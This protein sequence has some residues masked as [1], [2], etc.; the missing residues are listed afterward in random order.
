M[1]SI[2]QTF[3]DSAR[4]GLFAAAL[5]ALPLVAA[6]YGEFSNSQDLNS[7]HGY[8]YGKANVLRNGSFEANR[9]LTEWDG[10]WEGKSIN[11]SVLEPAD[12]NTLIS[13]FEGNRQLAVHYRRPAGTDSATKVMSDFF[14]LKPNRQYTLTI[15]YR[16]Q[17]SANS[18]FMPVLTQWRAR[19]LSNNASLG[20]FSPVLDGDGSSFLVRGDTL[21]PYSNNMWGWATYQQTFNTSGAAAFGTLHLLYSRT[22]GDEGTFAFDGVSIVEG[23]SP[24]NPAAVTRK[25]L[26]GENRLLQT[27]VENG[28]EAILGAMLYDSL[29]RILRTALPVGV[30]VGTTRGAYYFDAL[31]SFE[32]NDMLSSF[33]NPSGGPNLGPVVFG[34]NPVYPPA[35][36]YPY[37]ETRYES[38]PLGRVI[39]VSGPGT[40]W[41]MGSGHTATTAYSSTPLVDDYSTLPAPSSDNGQFFVK[42]FTSPDGEVTREF[43][44]RMGRLTRRASLLDGNWINTDYAYDGAGNLVEVQAPYT[45]GSRMTTTKAFDFVKQMTEETTPS[46]GTTTFLYD[47][48]GR[49]RFSSTEQQRADGTFSYLKYDNLGRVLETGEILYPPYF[50]HGNANFSDFPCLDCGDFTISP[51][52]L[53]V[54]TMNHY[55]DTLY[56]AL[57]CGGTPLAP[58]AVTAGNL[59]FLALN[60]SG[61]IVSAG[62]DLYSTF[63]AARSTL[64]GVDE[65]EAS[66]LFLAPVED[67]S[68]S[69]MASGQAIDLRVN[70]DLRFT[71]RGMTPAHEDWASTLSD[72]NEEAEKL[73]LSQFVAGRNLLGRLAKTTTCNYELADSLDAAYPLEVSKTF[74]YDAQ[75]N[76]VEVVEVNGYVDDASQRIQVTRNTYDLQ[77]RPLSK[78]VCGDLACNPGNSH[79]E[80]FV[81]DP[82][83][84]L[85][86]IQDKNNQPLVTNYYN[87]IGQLGAQ[88][89][90]GAGEEAPLSRR[91]SYRAQGWLDSMRVLDD[92]NAMVF[93]ETLY[94]ENGSSPRY[95]GDISRADVALASSVSSTYRNLSYAYQY[96]DLGRLTTAAPTPTNIYADAAYAYLPD[97][98]LSYF[99]QGDRVTLSYYYDAYG[100]LD[101]ATGSSGDFGRN[102]AANGGHPF[103]YDESGNLTVDHSK[104]SGTPLKIYYRPDGLPYLFTY[105]GGNKIFMAYDESGRRVSKIKRNGGTWQDTKTYFSSGKELREVNVGQ[106]RIFYS[107]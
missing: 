14:P 2:H 28:D 70:E 24:E 31:G 94:Y 16:S 45:N 68:Y 42:V 12:E 7:V 100:R 22:P 58:P 48:L 97:G 92:E 9:S 19:G 49:L 5:L 55:D 18:A 64:D 57:T 29:G 85:A 74:R 43:T 77:N 96:D 56:S 103:V 17:G 36:G 33:Y 10:W 15:R 102:F 13:P 87:A 62:Y 80:Y 34:E 47:D 76:I 4:R 59:A 91:Y 26:D 23:A 82:Q 105:A 32:Y 78:K 90:N 46:T 73:G 88:S 41:K 54:R 104:G 89:F 35:D 50:H 52:H 95:G 51:S 106:D 61:A 40:S 27:I 63:L 93:K 21:A 1:H 53:R 75:G 38:S 39:E 60:S 20:T 99:D 66:I 98:R 6:P 44:D 72:F 83:G 3:R 107:M 84:R 71:V 30:P 79:I 67:Q 101:Q 65:G 81:Y 8:M 37:S 25:Y 69:P 11:P 86:S